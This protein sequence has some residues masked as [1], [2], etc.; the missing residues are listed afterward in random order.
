MSMKVQIQLPVEKKAGSSTTT[1]TTTMLPAAGAAAATAMTLRPTVA[2]RRRRVAASHRLLKAG[3]DD[4]WVVDTR[5]TATVAPI[6][7]TRSLARHARTLAGMHACDARSRP[8]APRHPLATA[9]RHV[10]GNERHCVVRL[11]VTMEHR[12]DG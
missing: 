2:F 5:G 6:R 4:R 8:M 3:A 9:N 11:D 7:E 12:N 1:W 10:V